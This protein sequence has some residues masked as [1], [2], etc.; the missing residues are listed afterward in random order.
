MN[1]F[2]SFG[3]HRIL[4]NTKNLFAPLAWLQGQG[5]SQTMFLWIPR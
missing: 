5:T 1:L 4:E 3:C 2:A